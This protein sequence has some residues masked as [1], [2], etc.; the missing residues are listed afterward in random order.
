MPEE[1]FLNGLIDRGQTHAH[2]N[3]CGVG[4]SYVVV[5]H[6]GQIAQCQMHLDQSVALVQTDNLIPLIAQGPIQNLPVDEKEGCRDCE[7]RYRCTGGCPVETFR[8]TG[9]W[10]IKSPNCA[11]YKALWPAVLRLEGLRLLK[12]NG[13]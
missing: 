13:F 9:R 3:T 1:P 5:T 12:V 4:Q 8:A 2:T 6:T 7:F 11:I 10:D